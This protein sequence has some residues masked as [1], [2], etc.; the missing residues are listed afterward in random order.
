MRRLPLSLVLLF[1]CSLAGAPASAQTPAPEPTL[2]AALQNLG[3]VGTAR[4]RYWGFDVYDANLYAPS[5]FDPQRFEAQRFG[6]HFIPLVRERYFFAL[7]QDALASGEL[8]PVLGVL[9][10]PAFRARVAA[11]SGYDASATGTAMTL[12]EAFDR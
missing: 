3:K 1:L 11:L 10:A 4:L 7:D 12:G 6:L 5:G 8:Q 2:G 9:R